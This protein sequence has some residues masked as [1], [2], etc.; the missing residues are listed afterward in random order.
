[1]SMRSKLSQA[2]LKG[3]NLERDRV[4]RICTRL[5]DNLRTDL[6]KK[7]MSASEKHL[8]QVKFQMACALVGAVQMKVMSGIDPDAETEATNLHG[9]NPDALGG[10]QVDPDGGRAG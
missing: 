2:L 10:T 9:Q 8:A 1:M 3:Q 4:M 5:I 6:N 7:L